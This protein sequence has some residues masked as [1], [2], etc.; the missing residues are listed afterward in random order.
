MSDGL[1][2]TT[3]FIDLRSGD[4]AAARLWQDVR[5]RTMSAAYSA[6]TVFELWV[7]PSFSNEDERFFQG[8]FDRL[9]LVPVSG[10][11]AALAGR[12]LRGQTRPTRERR[13]RD[14]LIGASAWERSEPVYTRNAADF[15]RYSLHVQ[16]Y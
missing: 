5:A 9:E 14:A 11:A 8:V 4:A 1:L 3:F 16:A 6:V 12:W 15:R 13:M 10:F 7:G 2:D